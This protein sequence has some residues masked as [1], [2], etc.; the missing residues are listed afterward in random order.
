MVFAIAALFLH[1]TPARPAVP[2]TSGAQAISARSVAIPAPSDADAA[3][4]ADRTTTSADSSNVANFNLD[5]VTLSGTSN[6]A[7]G[8]SAPKLTAISLESAEN[9]S[10]LS[11]VRVPEIQPGKPAGVTAAETKPYKREWLTLMVVEHG[12]AAF[13]AYSTRQAISRGAVEDDPLMRP[14]AHSNA[15]YAATQVGPLL[16]DLVARH[17]L[18]SEN[19]FVR[20][21]WWIPQTASAATSIFA[22][23]H[24][25]GV[26][27]HQ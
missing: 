21:M 4:P 3:V 13:D 7:S 8:N 11:T 20:K 26:A 12:A 17:M 27:S 1:L 23:V 6:T 18:R 15:I 22:G 14:F 2:A 5:R 10:A 25:L 19:G 24:N 9:A 16:F